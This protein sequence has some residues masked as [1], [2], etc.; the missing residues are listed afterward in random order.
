MQNDPNALIEIAVG[1]PFPQLVAQ[2]RERA[3]LELDKVYFNEPTRY[4]VKKAHMSRDDVRIFD[5][6]G[7][8]VCN[9]HHPGKNPYDALD[10]L[11]MTNQDNRYNVMGGEW[12]SFCD[13]SAR[14][15]GFRSFKIRP[16]TMTMH[17]RQLIKREHGD[18][19]VVMNVGK[20]G[21][22]S[23]MS[24]RDTFEICPDT[25]SDEVYKVAADL[26]ARTYTF[27]NMKDEVVAVM[28]K[29]TKALMLTAA[30]GS[31]SEST[32]DIAA[33][34]D[35]SVIIA[36]VFGIMQVGS[37][38]IGDIANNYLFDPLKEQVIDGAV[39]AAGAGAAVDMYTNVSNQAHGN[40][41]W[42]SNVGRF[43]KDNVFK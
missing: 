3:E 14:G 10:P 1:A 24:I 25:G 5:S 18:G 34:V 21:K 8:L 33:G 22:L 39:D 40:M 28:A 17:G 16:K 30:F 42:A 20:M 4:L 23:T 36:G 35:N 11:G 12:E 15:G 2:K 19:D 13:V 26:M 32:L 27:T 38:V 7:R 29:T 41:H 43:I 6:N 9:S 37:S 31:G